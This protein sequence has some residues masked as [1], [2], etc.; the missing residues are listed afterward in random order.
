MRILVLIYEYPPIGGGGGR[1]AQDICGQLAR[2]GHQVRVLTARYGDLPAEETQDG[3]EIRRM[4]CGRTQAHRAGLLAMAGYV[5]AALPGGLREI[6]R[7]RPHVLHVH[8]AVPTGAAAWLLSILTKVPY[9][10]TVHLGDVPDG[11]P[12]K[13]AG[14][15]RWVRPF[16]PPIWRRAARVVAVSEH[17]RSLARRHY[18]VAIDLVPNGVDLQALDP[19]EIR[20]NQPPVVMFAGRLVP[21]K[22][23][24]QIVRSLAAVADLPWQALL[25]GEGPLRPAVAEEIARLGLGERVQLTGWIKPEQVIDHYRRADLLF[26]PSFTEG[27]PVAGVQAL[28]MGL[29]LVLSTAGGNVD[30]VQPGENGA[31][32]PVEQPQGFAAAL[33]DLLGDPQK[34]LAARQASRRLAQRFDLTRVVD[35]YEA[36]FMESMSKNNP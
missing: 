1:V 28:A 33:R 26:M 3:V 19:G 15:F 18:P 8:F 11:V 2:R 29:A 13:T 23:P 6:R 25:V 5:L 10:L 31:L 20:L 21:Q 36:I 9:V 22:N 35:A 12:E 17:T 27:L 34:L 4:R 14:W 16:T 32:V 24:L 7:W 30:L